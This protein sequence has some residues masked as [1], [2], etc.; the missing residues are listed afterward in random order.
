[1]TFLLVKMSYRRKNDNFNT[2][3]TIAEE[4]ARK[5]GKVAMLV[6]LGKPKEQW[7]ESW[8]FYPKNGHVES[9]LRRIT[10]LT[11]NSRL[12]FFKHFLLYNVNTR[13]QWRWKQKM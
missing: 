10:H 5:N 7:F 13:R 11:G 12:L 4:Y 6:H 2:F 1:M 9:I 8:E 3:L